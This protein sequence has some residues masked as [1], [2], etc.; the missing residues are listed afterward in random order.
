MKRRDFV[1]KAAATAGV[2]SIVPSFV[3]GGHHV[4]PS[5]TLYVAGIGVGGRGA[6]VTRSLN[7][8]G[9]VKFVALCDVD[10]VRAAETFKMFP[11]SKVY[12]DYRDVYDNHLNEI[13]AFYV[14]TP[15]HT[16]ALV[17]LPFIR[18]GKHAYIEKP[19]THNIAEARLLAN[20]I[21]K[22]GVVSQMG[23][24][25]SSG[26]G[27]RQTKEW[28]DAGVIGRVTKVDSWTNRPVWPQGVPLIT[29]TMPVP[30]TLDWNL[31]LGPAAMRGYNAAYLPFKWRGFWDFGTGAL[32]DMGCHILETS[33]Y[34]LELGDPKEAEASCTTVWVDDFV[35][36]RYEGSCPP[37][38]IVRLKFDTAKHGEMALSWYD[39]GL[40]PE[41]PEG[42][43]GQPL[44]DSGGGTVFYGTK[45]TLVTGT[46]SSN[47]RLIPQSINDS[48]T[49]PKPTIPRVTEAD[50]PHG[51]NFVEGCLE[52]KPTSSSIPEYAGP[53]TEAV[54]MGNLAIRAYQYNEVREGM[55]ADQRG[56]WH[57]PGRMTLKWDGDNMRVTNYEKAN[58]WVIR[59]YRTGWEVK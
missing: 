8:T 51:L 32:G 29:E 38:S 20:E 9:K 59:E 55:T 43:N 13:D 16:H 47:P 34:A 48:F 2:F 18:A 45:G 58:D 42:L 5:D 39:G 54:L 56:A 19:L 52:G 41:L 17:S 14:A 46:Y 49:P 37:S 57:H 25:G 4:P 30:D 27:I 7:A 50:E 53:L 40:K 12:A 26:E 33:F 10:S 1:K 15:D 22:A 3:M 36:S 6:S 23:N 11:K 44:G 24:Q 21:R 35:E 28:I 31:W